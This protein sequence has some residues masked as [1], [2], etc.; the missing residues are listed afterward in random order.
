MRRDGNDFNY[1]YLRDNGTVHSV[2][3]IEIEASVDRDGHTPPRRRLHAA[4][5]YGRFRMGHR[6]GSELLSVRERAEPA[7]EHQCWLSRF[8]PGSCQ[9]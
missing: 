4:D 7:S 3:D 5:A 1:G 9:G 2:G 8:E 6:V